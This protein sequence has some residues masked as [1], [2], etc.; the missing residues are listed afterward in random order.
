MSNAIGPVGT[1]SDILNSVVAATSNPG[2]TG[3][4]AGKLLNDI[5]SQEATDVSILTASLSIVDTKA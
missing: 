2:T 4:I 5:N 3:E 1:G